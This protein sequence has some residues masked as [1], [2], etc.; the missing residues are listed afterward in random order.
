MSSGSPRDLRRVRV[1][2]A[3]GLCFSEKSIKAA[4]MDEIAKM[5]G[6]SK[7]ILYRFFDSKD[8]LVGAVISEALESWLSRTDSA[9][10]EAGRAVVDRI[11]ARVRAAVTFATE[12][13]ILRSLL[14]REPELR[15]THGSRFFGAREAAL[16]RTH[17][18][19]GGEPMTGNLTETKCFTLVA[20][21]RPGSVA[22]HGLV[23]PAPGAGRSR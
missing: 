6:V 2:E 1:V 7:P 22:R 16:A 5:A 18:L 9:E 20:R 4:T 8:L 11:V 15:V 21:P 23:P 19:L 14:G 3:A 12:K 13:P 10:A 17:E